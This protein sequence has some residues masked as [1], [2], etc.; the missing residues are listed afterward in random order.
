MLDAVAPIRRP[1]G[2][3]RR[4]P[5]KLHA[6]KAYD[7]RVCRE[8][9]RRRRIKPRIARRGVE[10]SRRLGRHR[11]VVER[12]L[13]WLGRFRRLATRYE[14]RADIHQAFLT[15]GRGWIHTSSATPRL[16]AKASMGVR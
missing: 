7:H 10:D 13:A 2:R 6:D 4:R 16:A 5:D 3:P 1:K 11:W 14:R 9:C 15:L 12:T 8:D